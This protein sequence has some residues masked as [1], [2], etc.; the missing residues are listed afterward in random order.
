MHTDTCR[1]VDK[2]IQ[3]NV[4]LLPPLPF[5]PPNLSGGGLFVLPSW[6]VYWSFLP[7]PY[8]GPSFLVLLYWFFLPG[9]YTGSSFLVLILVLPGPS[10]LV[11]YW[12]F[13]VRI[14]VLPS[15]SLY[16]SFM[17]ALLREGGPVHLPRGR[18]NR[19]DGRRVTYQRGGA[20]HQDSSN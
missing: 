13:L 1:H 10:F 12:S 2:H 8:T 11:L 17:P 5:S 14:L 16:W 7:G 9:P 4:S 18:R 19:G 15:W 20:G 3:T 6:S